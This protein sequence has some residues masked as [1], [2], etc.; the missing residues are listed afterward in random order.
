VSPSNTVAWADAYRHTKWHLDLSSHLATTDMG[1]K[2]GALPLWGG[3]GG[4]PSNTMWP[5][6]RPTCMPSFIFIHLTVWPQYTNVRD[7]QTDRQTDNRPTEYGEPFYKR[8][9][10]N[11]GRA[12]FLAH[13]VDRKS[14]QWA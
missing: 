2:L 11:Q 6:T 9:P 3:G 13:P 4:S 12:G 8:S 7:K 10:K 1:R 14:V 5:G